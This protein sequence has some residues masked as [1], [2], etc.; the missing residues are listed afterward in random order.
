M[1]FA[2][3]MGLKKKPG[4]TPS[5]FPLCGRSEKPHTF[6]QEKFFITRSLAW[7]I[8]APLDLSYEQLFSNPGCGTT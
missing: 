2:L 6:L 4:F 5:E 1:N 3:V 7:A 8:T